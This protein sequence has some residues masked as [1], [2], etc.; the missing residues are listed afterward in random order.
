APHAAGGAALMID[1]QKLH[2]ITPSQIKG[3]LQTHAVDMDNPY[4]TGFD[5]GFDYATGY[6]LIRA[7]KAVGDVKFP[8]LF[9]KDLDIRPL[10]SGDPSHIRNWEVDNPNP[11][12]VKVDWLLVGTDQHGSITV[13]PGDTTFSTTTPY[14][15]NTPLPAIALIDWEDNFGFTRIDLAYSTRAVCGKDQ[16]SASN[17]DKLIST[18]ANR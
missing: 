12:E 10:C 9:V 4:T 3:I 17:S 8:N 13:P 16:V 14:F 1:A 15:H 6:G 18:D 11:F 2:T 5:K 7:D